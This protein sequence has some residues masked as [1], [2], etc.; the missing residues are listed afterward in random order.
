MRVDDRYGIR[1]RDRDMVWLDPN[2]FS[3]LLVSIIDSSEAPAAAALVEQPEIGE[4]SCTR[5]GD[6]TNSMRTE[7]RKKIEEKGK[8]EKRVGCQEEREKHISLAWLPWMRV[9][10]KNK[11][12]LR[13]HR[14]I[15]CLQHA[16]ATLS[17]IHICESRATAARVVK[18]RTRSGG[19]MENTQTDFCCRSRCGGCASS[20][21]SCGTL[22]S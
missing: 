16:R 12:D 4:S 22:P 2:Y 17:M 10:N 3:V 7:V 21:H 8:E 13:L 15:L 14:Q 11:I 5:A 1:V 18:M 20:E 6:V 19:V 9:S